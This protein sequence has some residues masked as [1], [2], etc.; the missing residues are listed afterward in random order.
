MSDENNELKKI[1]LVKV[2]SFQRKLF[3]HELQ[4]K[5][6][7]YK[8]TWQ[9]CCL[10]IDRRAVQF[11]TQNIIIVGIICFCMD[12]LMELNSCDS[13]PYLSLLTLLI[14]VLIPNPK[15]GKDD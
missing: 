3:E 2:D 15:F 6:N 12:R 13:Q 14:G 10:V 4:E 1:D 8:D 7:K 9:S 5:E 11:F